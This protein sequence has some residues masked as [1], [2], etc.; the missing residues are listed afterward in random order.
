MCQGS[1]NVYLQEINDNLSLLMAS[2]GPQ[3]LSVQA[4]CTAGRPSPWG[5][6]RMNALIYDTL[7]CKW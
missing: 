2:P 5:L 6:E 4:G 1:A 3:T 7:E